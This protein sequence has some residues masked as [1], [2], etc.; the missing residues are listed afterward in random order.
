MKS[1]LSLI[2]VS[3][4]FFSFKN[5]IFVGFRFNVLYKIL[6]GRCSAT[7]YVVLYRHLKI[8]V[9]EDSRV[10]PL[11]RKKSKSTKS[12]AVNDHMLMRPCGFI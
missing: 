2:R 12:T 6:C 7:Y 3:L 10:S 8:E 11:S 4:L 5:L 1:L 9:G